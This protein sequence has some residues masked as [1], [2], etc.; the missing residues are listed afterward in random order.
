MRLVF[1]VLFV[2]LDH[3]VFLKTQ[4]LVQVDGAWMELIFQT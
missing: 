3:G 1:I 2:G 4:D